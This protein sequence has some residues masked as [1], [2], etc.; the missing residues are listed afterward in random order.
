MDRYKA[1]HIFAFLGG[2]AAAIAAL[3]RIVQLIR[4]YSRMS[5]LNAISLLDGSGMKG[6]LWFTL[7]AET[8]VTLALIGAAVFLFRENADRYGISSMIVGAAMA[9][10]YIVVIFYLWSLLGRYA[11]MIIFNWRMILIYVALGLFSAAFIMSGRSARS[12]DAGNSVKKEWARGPLFFI[13]GIGLILISVAGQALSISEVFSGLFSN[14]ESLISFLLQ[15]CLLILAGLY[16]Y[17]R[18]INEWDANK[19]DTPEP[20]SPF[21]G[22]SQSPYPGPQGYP[23]Q[24]PYPGPQGYPG[25]TPYPGQAGYAGQTPY[26]G[27]TG[28]AG[29]TPYP[30]QTGYAGQTP[31]PG[32]QEA[33]GGSATQPYQG[34][35]GY[36]GPKVTPG[37]NKYQLKVDTPDMPEPP[38]TDSEKV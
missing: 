17:Y 7:L 33:P 9:L 1:E 23:G 20:D 13:G 32:P 21:G 3:I 2:T 22:Y 27:Q 14:G 34:Y 28:Y 26:P 30:G 12:L 31:Y 36:T 38:A 5:Q 4:S 10:E 25:Q 18:S 11:A 6:V 35:M 16:M 24:T 19:A 8:V 37:K 29:Q 15:I